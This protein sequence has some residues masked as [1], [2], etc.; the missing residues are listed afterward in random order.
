[1]AQPVHIDTLNMIVRRMANQ[2]PT[3]YYLD[4]HCDMSYSHMAIEFHLR[5]DENI[6]Q[7][8]REMAGHGFDLASIRTNGNFRI[9]TYQAERLKTW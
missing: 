7:L 8:E 4:L 3:R 1:M 2:C 6:D 5:P 9:L